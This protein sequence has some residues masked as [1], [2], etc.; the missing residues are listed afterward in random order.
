MIVHYVL[1]TVQEKITFREELLHEDKMGS[2][3][4]LPPLLFDTYAI[5]N[6]KSPAFCHL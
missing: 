2:A 3:Y 4:P 6:T 5:V 1:L